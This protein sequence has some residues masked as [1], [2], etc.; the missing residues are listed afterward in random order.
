MLPAAERP[1]SQA[2]LHL[3]DSDDRSFEL[4]ARLVASFRRGAITDLLQNSVRLLLAAMG[5]GVVEAL[6]DDYIA[7]A[8]PMLFPSDEALAFKRFM[9]WHGHTAPGLAEVLPGSKR[10]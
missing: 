9:E 5:P 10:R 3:T 7:E 6:M 1:A 4:Y 8:P 2:N